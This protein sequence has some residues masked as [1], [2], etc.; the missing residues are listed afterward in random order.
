M[1]TYPNR[2]NKPVPLAAASDAQQQPSAI[3][4]ASN[5]TSVTLLLDQMN[6][7]LAVDAAKQQMRVQPGM[8]VTKLLQ[9]A[10]SSGL[11]VPLG[12]VPAFGDLTLGGV[13]STG[14]HGT[15]HLT[16]SSLV[17]GQHPSGMNG[18]QA[19]AV[20]VQSS[21]MLRFRSTAPV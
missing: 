4:P 5:T 8:F 6:S 9:E 10:A 7:V 13:L 18:Q 21:M 17:R 12:S 1:H 16:T 11:S 2:H 3:R 20:A 19:A 14:A 15:G